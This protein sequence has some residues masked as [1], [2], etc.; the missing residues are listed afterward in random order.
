[1]RV[2]EE[3]SFEDFEVYDYYVNEGILFCY[4]SLGFYVGIGLGTLAF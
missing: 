2:D 1:M 4:V 3:Y